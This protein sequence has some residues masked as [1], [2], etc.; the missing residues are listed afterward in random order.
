MICSLTKIQWHI[1]KYFDDKISRVSEVNKRGIEYLS[2]TRILLVIVGCLC[3]GFGIVGIAIVVKLRLM[4]LLE[5]D[6]RGIS[7][8]GVACSVVV[9]ISKTSKCLQVAA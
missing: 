4:V 5:M 1:I 2:R 3:I 7:A 9:S 8:F 6:F